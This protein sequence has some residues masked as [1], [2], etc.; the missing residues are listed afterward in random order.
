MQAKS[1]ANKIQ[2]RAQETWEAFCDELKGAGSQLIR[3]DLCL[4]ELDAAEGL[5]YLSRMVR[6]GLERHVES[7]DP[8][9]AFLYPLSDERIKGFGGEGQARGVRGRLEG[10]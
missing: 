2:R 9:I 3:D 1:T 7:A 6:T 5:R 8:A 4:D 10:F